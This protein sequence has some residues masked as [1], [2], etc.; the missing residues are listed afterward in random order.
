LQQITNELGSFSELSVAVTPESLEVARA[1]L[2]AEREALSQ[3]RLAILQELA[4]SASAVVSEQQ[5]TRPGTVDEYG[6]ALATAR[7]EHE[8]LRDEVSRTDARIIELRGYRD[9]VHD[10]RERLARAQAAGTVLAPLRVTNCPV[11]D[12]PVSRTRDTSDECYLCRQPDERDEAAPSLGSRRIEYEIAQ[13]TIEESELAEVITQAETA[14]QQLQA[15]L[16][17]V[18]RTIRTV[19]DLLGPTRIAAAARTRATSAIFSSSPSV[20]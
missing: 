18:Q 10:E 15:K 9:S 20:S 16:A 11:C 5:A 12:R 7:A 19:E 3:R 6:E 1:R 14:R 13:L 17:D 2:V 4:T 8:R